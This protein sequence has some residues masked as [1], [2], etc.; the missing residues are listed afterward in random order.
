LSWPIRHTPG[1]PILNAWILWWNTQALPL[2]EAWWNAPI[3]YPMPGALALSEHL[4]GIAVFTTPL[5]FAGL[6]PVAASNVTLILSF[7][8]SGLFAYLLGTRLTGSSGAGLVAGIAFAF[9][10]YRASHLSHLQVLTSQWMPLALLGMHRY[11]DEGRRRWLVVFAGAW[12]LQA[13]SNGYYLLFFPVLVALWLL[14]FVNW[15]TQKL[16]GLVLAGTFAAASLLLVPVLWQYKQIHA[17]LGLGRS[18]EEMAQFSARLTSFFQ[19]AGLLK[20][21]PS[22]TAETQEQFLF[23]G[24]T[25]LVLV[26]AGAAALVSRRTFTR[27]ARRR[28]A[29]LFYGLSA[30]LLWWLCLGTA[31][32]PSLSLALARPY[33]LLTWAPGFEGLRV[34]AR[35]AMIAT[36]SMAMAAAISVAR[37]APAGR[38]AGP[39]IG[40]LV[41]GGLFVDGW[42]EPLPLAAPP[43]N[44]L[45]RTAAAETVIELPAGNPSV[46]V[47]AMYRSI[48]HRL[49]LVNG[50]S[51][52]TPRHYDVLTG[53]LEHRDPS[54]LTHLARGRS[55]VAIVHRAHD[56][57]GEWQDLVRQA[58][59]I[60]QDE[61]AVGPVFLIPPQPRT[62]TVA[63]TALL[64]LTSTSSTE[65]VTLDLG[66]AL[67]VRAVSIRL[68]EHFGEIDSRMTIESSIDRTQWTTIWEGWTG[69]AAL[70]AA[71]EDPHTVPMKIY[72]HDLRTRYL[73]VSPVPQWVAGVLG[74]HG[75]G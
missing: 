12:V 30:L 56:P 37:L 39:G 65:A 73:R 25:V 71:L 63:T 16:R 54:V 47:A 9:A 41:I 32:E 33:T 23:P 49:P 29:G 2:T 53:S 60:L 14:W 43:P 48:E 34:P 45:I 19:P 72:L 27:T 4:A 7:W 8:L 52:H 22:G 21:W 15:R 20:F 62:A 70:S 18:V 38:V 74:V 75:P 61:S 64:P 11:L 69:E 51:G 55:L 40:L 31:G 66:S 35:F 1:D 17:A 3:F 58:G 28:S 46:N 6:D 68:G 10:P 57:R 36:L 5:Q 13:L 26:T 24:L 44:V 59:G 50:Y 67:A 42:I